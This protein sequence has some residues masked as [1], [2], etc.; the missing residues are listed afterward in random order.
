MEKVGW[1]GT[2]VE[3]GMVKTIIYIDLFNVMVLTMKFTLENFEIRKV[4]QEHRFHLQLLKLNRN[5]K[6]VM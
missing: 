3:V 5:G 4:M 6:F 1:T 2:T